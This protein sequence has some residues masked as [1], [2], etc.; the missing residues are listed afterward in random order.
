MKSAAIPWTRRFF[1]LGCPCGSKEPS[2]K[3]CWRG[4]GRWEKTPVGPISVE[5]SDD[6]AFANDRCYLS[7][8]H[9]CGSKITKEHFISRNILEQI[10]TDKLKFAGAGHFFGGKDQV[11]IGIDAFSAKVLCDAHN[12]AL[13]PLDAAA[14]LAFSTFESLSR[15][16]ERSADPEDSV[17][18]FYLSSGLDIERW[19]IK[20]YCGLLAAGKIRSQS[21]KIQEWGSISSGLLDALMGKSNLASPLGLYHHSFA[22][23]TR[24]LGG[25]TIGTIMLNDGSDN[26]GGLMLSLGIANLVLITSLGFGQTFTEPSWHR[27][28]TYLFKVRQNKSRIVYLLTY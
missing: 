17:T 3:C 26:V 11:E 12:S 7:A 15:D 21:G 27:H 28:P 2:Y 22:G 8:L 19:M 24:R 25:I 14:G 1:N 4:D 18:S 10:T 23:Q 13:S 5:A 9:N 6:S 20:V 16:I